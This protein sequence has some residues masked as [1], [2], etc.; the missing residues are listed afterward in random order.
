M[1][2]N[3]KLITISSAFSPENK[4]LN[5]LCFVTQAESE[6]H[7][8]IL[9]LGGGTGKRKDFEPETDNL[10][11]HHVHNL[12]LLK[13]FFIWDASNKRRFYECHITT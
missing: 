13:T 5:N 8:N 4:H 1:N 3:L 2:L 7:R 11:K 12:K 10:A 6:G 9:G